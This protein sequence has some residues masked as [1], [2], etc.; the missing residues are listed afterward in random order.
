MWD[1]WIFVNAAGRSQKQLAWS[2]A[3]S[4]CPVRFETWNDSMRN[5]AER[6]LGSTYGVTLTLDVLRVWNIIQ[7]LRTKPSPDP[8]TSA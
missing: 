2:L 5:I 7:D 8:P 4:A 6:D 3:A 1:S